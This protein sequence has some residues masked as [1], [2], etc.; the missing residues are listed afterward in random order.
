MLH[1]NRGFYLNNKRHTLTAQFVFIYTSKNE[2]A[3]FNTYL[4]VRKPSIELDWKLQLRIEKIGRTTHMMVAVRYAPDKTIIVQLQ[5]MTAPTTLLHIEGK[6][7]V[8]I[9]YFSP[10]ILEGKINEL[11]AKEFDVSV[12]N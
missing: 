1:L 6:L 4:E 11:V 12:V 5:W 9:P 10:L 2:G 8:T 7:N 3:K